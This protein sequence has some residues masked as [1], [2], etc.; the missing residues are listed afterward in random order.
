VKADV[1]DT[2]HR[3]AF[4]SVVKMCAMKTHTLTKWV[5]ENFASIFALGAISK[6]KK[7]FM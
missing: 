1:E 3:S 4:L 5:T 2:Q 7:W 6:K